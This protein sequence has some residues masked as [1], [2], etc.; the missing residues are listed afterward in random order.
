MAFDEVQLDPKISYG[1]VGGP[2]YKTTVIMSNSGSEQRIS[3]YLRGRLSWDIST[4]IKSVAQM[5]AIL[6][7]FRARQGKGRGF[8]FKDWTDYTA[9]HEG[10]GGTSP[11]QLIKTYRD[12]ANTEVRLIKKPIAGITIWLSDGMVPPGPTGAPLTG[13]TLDTTTG[14]VSGL[15]TDNYVWSGQFD[16]PVR[17]DTDEMHMNVAEFAT[18]NWDSIP[19]VELLLL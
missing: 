5:S 10:F 6:T 15:G 9:V 3:Q 7:F 16:T 19:V 13:W 12:T 2:K 18:R 8:R 17:F 14:L 4:G 1:A 11:Q